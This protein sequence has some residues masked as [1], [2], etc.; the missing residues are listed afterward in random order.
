M[1]WIYKLDFVPSS[2]LEFAAE[3]GTGLQSARTTHGLRQLP[4]PIAMLP[5]I[6]LQETI[7][8]DGRTTD[9]LLRAF[10]FLKRHAGVSDALV[11]RILKRF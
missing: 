5:I 9:F 6:V 8:A 10:S 3:A 2:G 4:K 11:S 1:V 7:K